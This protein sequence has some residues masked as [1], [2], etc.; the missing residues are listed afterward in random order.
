MQTVS[1]QIN[2]HRP[3]ILRPSMFLGRWAMRHFLVILL[4]DAAMAAL[5]RCKGDLA[6]DKI[7]MCPDVDVRQCSVSYARTGFTPQ[8]IQCAVAGKSCVAFGPLCEPRT[9]R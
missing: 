8:Y 7:W 1:A 3:P 6:G 5:D 2:R 9:P 4:G